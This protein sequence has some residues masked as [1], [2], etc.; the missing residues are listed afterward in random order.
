MDAN[1]LETMSFAE[2]FVESFLEEYIANLDDDAIG[3]KTVQQ[4]TELK[5]AWQ[6][7]TT[8]LKD[9]RRENTTLQIKVNAGR[10]A[11]S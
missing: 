2:G 6:T 10:I 3:P 7:L 1:R 4:I 11:L 5:S 8:G 9:L